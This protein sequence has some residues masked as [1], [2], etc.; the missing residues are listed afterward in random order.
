M[1]TTHTC[2]AVAVILCTAGA[3][4][5][6]GDATAPEP[7]TFEDSLE[8][9]LDSGFAQTSGKGFSVAVLVSGRPMWTGARGVSHGTVAITPASVFAAGSITKTFT[10][11]TI[12]RLAEEGM[13]SLDDSLFRW[14]PSYPYVDS[15]IT[16]R[17]LLNHTSGLSDFTD[18]QGWLIP[19]LE[20]PNRVWSM[21]EWFLATIQP[22]YFAK[23]TS[24]SYSTSGYLLLRMIIERATGSTVAAQYHRY[25]IDPLSLHDTYVCPDDSLPATVAH[26]WLDIT[27]DG[28]YDDFATVPRTAFCSAAG[29]QIF[30]TPTDLAKLGNALMR[31]R[32]I[33]DDASYAEMTDFVFPTGHD[34]PLVYGYGLGF[35]WFNP[36]FFSGQ[37]VW[38][39][40]GNAP[41]YAAAMLYLVDHDAVVALGDNTDAGDG[42]GTLDAILPVVVGHTTHD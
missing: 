23:G 13:L 35:L 30:S 25:V 39:H 42:M 31:E 36:T 6:A 12:L 17:Q 24:W 22:P 10:S 26:G 21:E 19:L 29:G 4:A 2:R 11:L 20:E 33:L 3:F 1:T 34:E 14:L 9:A 37:K 7:T 32:T 5:C 8:A 16:I 27:G 15:T 38:G 41:G 28:V 18:A 40:S